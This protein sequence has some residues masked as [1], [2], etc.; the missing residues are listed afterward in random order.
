MKP[1][2]SPSRGDQSVCTNS[3]TQGHAAFTTLETWLTVDSASFDSCKK[4]ERP[5]GLDPDT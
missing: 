2:R 1:T 5:L 4:E 3:R